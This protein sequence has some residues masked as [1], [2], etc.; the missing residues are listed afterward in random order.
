MFTLAPKMAFTWP[1]VVRVP[2][3]GRVIEQRFRAQFR[4]ADDALRHVIGEATTDQQMVERTQA[5]MRE[6][7]V[8]IYDV[9]DEAG[10]PLALTND[11]R[12]ALL[13][14][15]IIL[16]GLTDAYAG[17]LAGKPSAAEAGN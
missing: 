5:L 15:P 8:Q 4:I 7:L 16:R 10:V 6:A 17:A 12:E 11:V 14:N 9:V 13:A 3:D 2:D 1:V